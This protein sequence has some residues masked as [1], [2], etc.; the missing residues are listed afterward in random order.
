MDTL[1]EMAEYGT[2]IQTLTTHREL[3][4]SQK[5]VKITEAERAYQ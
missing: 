5:S 1:L 3:D 2:I 4:E